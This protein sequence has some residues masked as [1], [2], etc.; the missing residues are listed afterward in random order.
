MSPMELR[1]EAPPVGSDVS[2]SNGVGQ[3]IDDLIA[4]GMVILI[5]SVLISRAYRWMRARGD[6]P[7]ELAEAK[8]RQA[9]EASSEALRAWHSGA[10]VP[11]PDTPAADVEPPTPAQTGSSI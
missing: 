5:G 7:R 6:H 1:Y 10:P 11:P 2:L 3:W 4:G 8:L 9:K